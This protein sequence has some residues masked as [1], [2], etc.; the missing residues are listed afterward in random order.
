MNKRLFYLVLITTAGLQLN[1]AQAQ[2]DKVKFGAYARTFYHNTKV[3]SKD[4]LSPKKYSEGYT[5]ADLSVN[6]N[7]DKNTEIQSIL[8]FSSQLGGF[9][10]SGDIQLRMIRVKGII[11]KAVN[12]EVGDMF[13]ELSPYTLYNNYSEGGINEAAV[14][15]DLRN[16]IAYYD[17]RATGNRWWQQ[18]V[19]LDFGLKFD[20]SFLQGLKVD[21]FLLRNRPTTGT[22]MFATPT[23]FFAGGKLSIMQSEKMQIAGNFINLYDD[24]ELSNTRTESSNAVGTG[25]L[26]YKNM[27]GNLGFNFNVEGGFSTLNTD[28]NNSKINPA[29]KDSNKTY[30][31]NFF[32]INSGVNFKPWNITFNAGFTYVGPEFY[33]A[34][35]QSKRVDYTRATTFYPTAANTF[36]VQRPVTIF[37]L[38]RDPGIYNNVIT[39]QLMA[40]NPVFSNALPYGKATPN[41]SGLNLSLVYAD[42]LEKVLANVTSYILNDV[43][44]EGSKDYKTFMVIRGE[45]TANINKFINWQKKIAVTAGLQLENTSRAGTAVGKTDKVD[46]SSTLI[47]A[48]LELE[49][50]K[51]LDVVGG[52]KSLVASGNEFLPTRNEN[53]KIIVYTPANFDLS[54]NLIAYG[55]KYRFSKTS[56]LTI[57]NQMFDYV[58]N[59]NKSFTVNFNQVFFLFTMKL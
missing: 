27:F 45:V 47:D 19:H 37:D 41:R 23:S 56:Y 18:G 24:S 35:A 34:G 53:N 36:D 13:I 10:S 29:N 17:N 31:D 16:D 48:G 38:S 40:Y 15:K 22:G 43:R 46:L 32:D 50:A 26:H 12:Y 2:S 33:S 39:R 6:I 59:K 57:Q 21:G 30:S 7:P 3:D 11:A 54:Q 28:Y 20:N 4:T 52:F 1:S 44:P 25:E 42:S 5:L 51:K 49:I 8:R 14:F 58:D 55:I 9:Y